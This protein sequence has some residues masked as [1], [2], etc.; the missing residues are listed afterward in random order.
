MQFVSAS[1]LDHLET[2]QFSK[3]LSDAL[4]LFSWRADHPYIWTVP[5]SAMHLETQRGVNSFE[6]VWQGPWWWTFLMIRWRAFDHAFGCDAASYN[7]SVQ[8]NWLLFTCPAVRSSSCANWATRSRMPIA[9]SKPSA[10]NTCRTS[11][12][13]SDSSRWMAMSLT[14]NSRSLSFNSRSLLF[15]LSFNSTS[16][17]FNLSFNCRSLLSRDC[18]PSTRLLCASVMSLKLKAASAD[19]GESRKVGTNNVRFSPCSKENS[20]EQKNWTISQVNWQRS[21]WWAINLQHT[22]SRKP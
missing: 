13:F 10:D 14:F 11:S 12:C 1:G 6:A 4:A 5:R 8:L 20:F 17:L 22:P 2:Q 15:N 9:V 19:M 18:R 21:R 3:F 16:L 7:A